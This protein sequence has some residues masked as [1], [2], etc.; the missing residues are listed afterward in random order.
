MSH[1]IDIAAKL[2]R[3]VLLN[4][5]ILCVVQQ[6]SVNCITIG[7]VLRQLACFNRERKLCIF[8][9]VVEIRSDLIIEDFDL[10]LGIQIH[11]AEDS[12]QT[13]KVLILHVAAVR[14]TVNLYGYRVFPLM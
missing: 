10:I 5:G 9:L 13:D 4:N 14:P 6:A 3:E 11:I 1:F 12:A 8:V 7:R 2:N